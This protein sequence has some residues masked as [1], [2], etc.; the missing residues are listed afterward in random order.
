MFVDYLDVNAQT[1]DL[2]YLP[3]IDQVWSTLLLAMYFAC[4]DLLTG[5]ISSK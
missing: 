4:F 2:F 5:F 1:E 3:L